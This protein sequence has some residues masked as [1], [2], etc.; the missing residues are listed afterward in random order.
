[1]IDF[2]ILEMDLSL[3]AF[4]IYA[5]LKKFA[6]HHTND[7]YP[8]YAKLAIAFK[9]SYPTSS[10]SLWRKKAIAAIAELEEKGVIE[11]EL[12]FLQNGANRT[13]LYTLTPPSEWKKPSPESEPRVV[14]N[15][16]YTQ[17][18]TLTT[19]SPE[20]ELGVVST[21]VS[22]GSC[23]GTQTR[24]NIELYPIELDPHEDARA[25]ND[26]FVFLSKEKEAATE[27]ATTTEIKTEQ[28]DKKEFNSSGA[29][30]PG[31]ALENS[32]VF[33]SEE[34]M[35]SRYLSD[36]EVQEYAE[37][38]NRFAPGCCPRCPKLDI[39][40]KNRIRQLAKD[41]SLVEF[42]GAVC[43]VRESVEGR[44]YREQRFTFFRFIDNGHTAKMFSVHADLWERDESYRNRVTGKEETTIASEMSD[45]E[46]MLMILFGN[47]KGYEGMR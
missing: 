8:S 40:A 20:L 38:W 21:Q 10:P 18:Q 28:L 23:H 32:A 35:R 39:R 15:D 2:Q 36:S 45:E 44:Y 34:R 7:C 11:K 3:D 33:K 24:S 25:K 17:S 13:N 43:A 14:L 27:N 16:D 9:G 1:M 47:K 41:F 22:G 31:L 6:N 30:I 29:I 46:E 4:R 26:V 19:P 12:R 37:V 5:E 42:G